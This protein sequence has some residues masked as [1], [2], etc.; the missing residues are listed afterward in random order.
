MTRQRTVAI[1]L[2]VEGGYDC[3]GHSS[4]EFGWAHTLDV[5]R[6][7]NVRATMF[8]RGDWAAAHP[9]LLTRSCDE[10]HLIGNHTLNHLD[11]QTAP[12]QV[13]NQVRWC[14]EVLRGIDSRASTRPWFRLPY[15]SG[16]KSPHLLS[17]LD[18]LGWEHVRENADGREWSPENDSA[19]RVAANALVDAGDHP[20]IVT[21]LHTWPR[22]TPAAL[23]MIIDAYA[24][25]GA[26]FVR[27]DELGSDELAGLPARGPS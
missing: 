3:P 2:D 1:T 9:T 24:A 14:Y 4:F 12:D 22:A 26:R 19:S 7:T 23:R 10:G 8:V 5:L 17:A 18:R 21:L 16:D 6:E 20:L 11:L 27:I 15:L 13:G 25:E